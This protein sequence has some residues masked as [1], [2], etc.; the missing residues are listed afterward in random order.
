MI[1]RPLPDVNIKKSALGKPISNSAIEQVIKGYARDVNIRNWRNYNPTLLRAYFAAE[2]V[3][4]KRSLK[5]LQVFMRHNE[6]STTMRYVSRIIFCE[7]MQG[8]FDRIQTGPFEKLMEKPSLNKMLESPIVRQCMKCP[9]RLVCR[10]ADEAVQSEWAT[11][12]RF[13]PKIMVAL[14]SFPRR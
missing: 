13:Y 14:D 5:I 9:A 12:C 10:H 11:G 3:S 1:I 6:L 4:Q 7:E 8:E 2:W